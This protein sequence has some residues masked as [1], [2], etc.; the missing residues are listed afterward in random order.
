MANVA[1]CKTPWG[2]KTHATFVVT[3][4]TLCGRW[5]CQVLNGGLP[6]N[7]LSLKRVDCQIC[8]RT[9]EAYM[10]AEAKALG[11]VPNV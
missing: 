1:T 7:D 6:I 10:E 4:A 9:L 11:K 3:N 2:D 5:V 8:R